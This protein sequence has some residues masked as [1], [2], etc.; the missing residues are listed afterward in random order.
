ME[1]WFKRIPSFE[2]AADAVDFESG[3]VA[4]MDALPLRW[5]R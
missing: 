3:I 4:N 1:E 2:L 5:S